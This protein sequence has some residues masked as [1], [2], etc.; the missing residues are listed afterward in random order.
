MKIQVAQKERASAVIKKF[1]T[2]GLGKEK[3]GIEV[4]R[5][6][7]II[8]RYDIVPLPKT[9]EFIEGMIS[10][11]GEIIPVVDLRKRFSLT[12]KGRDAD[13]RIIVIE[14]HDFTIGIQVDKVFEV[15]KLSEDDIEPPPPLVSGL[16]TEYI[17]GVA[18]VKN[19]LI[20]ILNL[21]EIFS[22]TEKLVL[23]AIEGEGQEDEEEEE[24]ARPVKTAKAA[25]PEAE[26]EK[27]E[28]PA[29]IQT[30][31][32]VVNG[33]GMIEVRGKTY[34]VGKKF[35]GQEVTLKE[36]GGK[37]L[38]ISGTSLFKEFDV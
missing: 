21:D 25:S 2:L 31:S 28:G 15:L 22:T 16:K 9:P 19:V 26:E 17:E 36:D 12:S 3:Y 14:L 13:T 32:A 8:A 1:V 29:E 38:V 27:E 10:L 35:K 20:T 7:E 33:E 34:F 18:E 4:S 30:R 23:G 5:A 24:E 11:R 37:L 6:K